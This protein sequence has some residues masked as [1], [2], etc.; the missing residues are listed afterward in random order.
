MKIGIIGY[1]N[2]GKIIEKIALERGHEISTIIDPKNPKATHTEIS[3][4]SL[5]DT[6]VAIDFTSPQSALKN[7][8]KT[9]SL[10]KNLVV[11]TT[12]WYD[13]LE[14][15][16]QIVAK[17]KTGLIY[18]SN[19]SIGMN[20][21]SRIVENSAKIIDNFDQYDVG[22]IELHHNKKADS[23][24]GTAKAL[25]EII[26]KNIKRKNKIV[27][28]MVDGQIKPEELHFAS[29]RIGFIPGTHKIIMD[30]NADT[31]ELTHTARNRDGFALGAIF[32]AEWIRKKTGFYSVDDFMDELMKKGVTK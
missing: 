14:K 19:F 16:R 2:M 31:I 27:Y 20:I 17:N 24:G 3:K 4:E 22:G 1:G 7:I 15:A 25:A 21:F 8:E 18:A 11:G 29:A 13:Q 9:S 5:K 32:A 23:P 30:S 28:E 10:R 6:D 12:G 26:K